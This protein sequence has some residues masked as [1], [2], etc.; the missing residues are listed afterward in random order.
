MVLVTDRGVFENMP[1]STGEVN[2]S[3]ALEA[4]MAVMI[5]EPLTSR[6]I[7]YADDVGLKVTTP[8]ELLDTLDLCPGRLEE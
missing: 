6:A 4:A 8:D 2:I 7:W 3:T 5:L 1:A